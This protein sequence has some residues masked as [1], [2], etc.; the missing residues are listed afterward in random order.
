MGITERFRSIELLLGLSG[1]GNISANYLAMIYWKPH[2]FNIDSYVRR[3]CGELWGIPEE[4]ICAYCAD[5]Y[6]PFGNHAPLALWFELTRHWHS[7]E[8]DS[9]NSEW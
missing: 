5:R 2:D 8:S 7:R 9:S 6:R 1:I 3:R 4:G